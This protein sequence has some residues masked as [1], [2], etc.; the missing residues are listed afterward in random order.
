LSIRTSTA[1]EATSW[2]RCTGI[3]ATRPSTRAAMSRRVA[4]TSP[5][6]SSGS[7]RTK[8]QID[9]PATAATTMATMI[10]GAR[11]G[12]GGRALGFS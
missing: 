1:P 3:S 12:T 8:Y 9:N 7:D 5:C 11:E 2:P 6:T 10:A 4:S